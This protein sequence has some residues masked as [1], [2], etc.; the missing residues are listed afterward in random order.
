MKFIPFLIRTGV[1][2]ILFCLAGCEK[3]PLP[4][5]PEDGDGQQVDVSDFRIV[6]YNIHGGK[7]PNGEGSFQSN[8]TAFRSL[9]QGES[10]LCFQEVEPDCWSAL[11]SIFSDYP[12]RYFLPQTS[13][14]FGTNKEGGNAILSKFT[15]ETFDQHLVQTDPGGDK[16]ERKAQYVRIYIGNNHQYLNLFHY[17]NTFNWHESNSVSEKAGLE[18][19]MSYVES[20]NIPNSE[21]TVILGDFNL[22]YTQANEIIPASI[23]PNSTTNWVDHIFTNAELLNVG[24]Y[25]TYGN[26]LSDHQAVWMVLCNKDC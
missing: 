1:L 25:N 18:K 16:W 17:H 21:M 8:L 15:I 14:K 20:K 26:N 23:Y 9:L 13:T 11:K 6:S 2:S 10:I 5:F 12:Y 3:E 7:G 22:N 19:F 24:F 4:E